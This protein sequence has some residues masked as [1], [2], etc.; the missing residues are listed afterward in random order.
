MPHVI[1]EHSKNF[2]KKSIQEIQSEIQKIMSS[3]TEGK[4]NPDQCK[5]RSISYDEYLVG[6]ANHSNASFVHISIKI[7]S[8]RSAEV[9]KKLA[10]KTSEFV[11]KVFKELGLKTDRCDISV[12]LMEM[13][14]ETYQK[15]QI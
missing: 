12:D 11:Q 5:C 6:F 2:P 9:R 4:F 14:R 13:D 3:I 1:I 10:T 15:V 7:L 8:G